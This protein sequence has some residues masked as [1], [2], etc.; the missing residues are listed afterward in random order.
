MDLNQ[1]LVLIDVIWEVLSLDDIPSVG[2]VQGG[3]GLTLLWLVVVDDLL[4]GGAGDGQGEEGE[5]RERT[6]RPQHGGHSSDRLTPASLFIP[7][8]QRTV[9]TTLLPSLSRHT[10][11]IISKLYNII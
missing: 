3:P 7:G 11:N 4:L 5:E 2:G 1:P 8:R 9:I 6:T 10:V